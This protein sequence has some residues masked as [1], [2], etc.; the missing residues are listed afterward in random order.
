MSGIERDRHYDLLNAIQERLWVQWHINQLK[1]QRAF[2]RVFRFMLH[3]HG[4]LRMPDLVWI[5]ML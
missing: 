4:V 2:A 3:V 1:K 5:C